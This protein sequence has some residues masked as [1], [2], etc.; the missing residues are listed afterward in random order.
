MFAGRSSSLAHGAV[1]K[2]SGAVKRALAATVCSRYLGR[3]L[4]VLPLRK[5]AAVL[6]IQ[7]ELAN[8]RDL[9]D[10][11]SLAKPEL[12]KT[13]AVQLAKQLT[14]Q[15]AKQANGA[16]CSPAGSTPAVTHQK[17]FTGSPSVGKGFAA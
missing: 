5:Q 8:G 3:H 13:A 9:V 16:V 7:L 4:H 2:V 12:T 15:V 6:R 17:V 14:S 10:A 11:I 1:H